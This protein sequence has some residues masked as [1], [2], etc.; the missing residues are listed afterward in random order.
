MPHKPGHMNQQLLDSLVSI[1]YQTAPIEVQE[2]GFSNLPGM[3][4]RLIAYKP[5]S[6]GLKSVPGLAYSAAK[7]GSKETLK[8]QNLLTFIILLKIWLQMQF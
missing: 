7:S 5:V 8:K 2:M 4:G 3:L 6:E 1:D